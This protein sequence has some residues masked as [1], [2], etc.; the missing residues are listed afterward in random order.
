MRAEIECSV[1][2]EA[3]SRRSGCALLH[4]RL[5]S[6]PCCS[7]VS[8]A[9]LS[10]ACTDRRIDIIISR[11]KS[12]VPAPSMS[13]HAIA[14][15]NK[16]L[17]FQCYRFWNRWSLS[18]YAKKLRSK[19]KGR[20]HRHLRERLFS[21]RKSNNEGDITTAQRKEDRRPIEKEAGCW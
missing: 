2:V 5:F 1:F 10:H 9:Q 4:L 19:K 18:Q 11:L 6:L 3:Q 8:L 13:I 15:L 21:Q 17:T 20:E 14:S 12:R 16:S 7:E